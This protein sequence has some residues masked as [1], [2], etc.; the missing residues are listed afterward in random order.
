M[1]PVPSGV[2]V[3]L[4][5]G[6][7]DMRRGMNGLALQVQERLGRDPFAGDLFEISIAEASQRAGAGVVT[8]A[9]A[10]SSTVGTNS[11]GAGACGCR[12]AA[13][14]SSRN[15]LTQPNSCEGLMS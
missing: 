9:G 8:G 2:R 14:T 4:G 5:D 10:V 13:R 1:I 7:T 11:S 12:L 6:R 3:W 15:C